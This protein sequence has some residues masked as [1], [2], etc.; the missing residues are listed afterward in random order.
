MPLMPKAHLPSGLAHALMAG[1]CLLMGGCTAA[2]DG[3]Q[4]RITQIAPT[5]VCSDQSATVGL[6]GQNFAP[7]QAGSGDGLRLPSVQ[8]QRIG[9]TDTVL[10]DGASSQALHWDNAQQMRLDL[11]AQSLRAGLWQVEITNPGGGRAVAPAP[12][13]LQGAPTID[14]IVGD[15]GCANT[16]HD[17]TYIL[18]G[19]NFVILG[20][21]PPTV[22]IDGQAL[23]PTW[24]ASACSAPAG[25][26]R[27]VVCNRLTVQVPAAFTAG[28]HTVTVQNPAPSTSCNNLV[29]SSNLDI[30]GVVPMVSH[31][32]APGSVS[33]CAGG[34]PLTIDGNFLSA[35]ASVRIGASAAP[36]VTGSGCVANLD[37]CSTVVANFGTITAASPAA[38][39][40][41]NPGAC[42]VQ[43][44]AV[45]NVIPGPQVYGVDPAVV[46]DGIPNKLTLYLHGVNSTVTSVIAS[47]AG[48]GTALTLCGGSAPACT[49]QALQSGAAGDQAL[50]L[51]LPAGSLA[52]LTGDA[53]QAAVTLEVRVADN[54][55]SALLPAGL[56]IANRQPDIALGV[57]PSTVQVG[58]HRT[59]TV[60]TSDPHIAPG[61]RLYYAG[62]NLQ[63]SFVQST[64]QDNRTFMAAAPS[65]SLSGN[66]ADVD[67]VLVNPDGTVYVQP[68]GL[69]LIAASMPTV[70]DMSG[71]IVSGQHGGTLTTQTTNLDSN[72][73]ASLVSC[74]APDGQAQPDVALGVTL[75]AN[76]LQLTTPQ[77]GLVPQRC[78]LQVTRLSD[79][80]QVLGG[81]VFLSD[82]ASSLPSTRDAQQPLRVA[83]RRHGIAATIS[84]AS[85][86]SLVIAGGDN[87]QSPLASVE[88]A[89]IGANGALG[90][91]V[92]SPYSLRTPRSSASLL[93]V[94]NST[95]YAIGGAD[96]AGNGITTVERAVV[97]NVNDAPTDLH[98][99]AFAYG[100]NGL[101]GLAA[102]DWA[103]TVSLLYTAN[104]ALY[105]CGESLPAAPITVGASSAP[106]GYIPTV[107]WSVPNTHRPLRGVR[108]YRGTVNGGSSSLRY[109]TDLVA[110]DGNFVFTDGS[111][112]GQSPA[113]LCAPASADQ[114]PLAAGAL[115]PWTQL[116]AQ[117]TRPRA[118]GSFAVATHASSRTSH[119][120]A[121][122]GLGN[123]APLQDYEVMNL[124]AV[125][126]TTPD[127]WEA[128]QTFTAAS[129]PNV[130]GTPCVGS[131]ARVQAGAVVLNSG[132]SSQDGVTFSI[133]DE[134]QYL[135]LGPGAGAAASIAAVDA[136][137]VA[138]NGQLQDVGVHT[139][140]SKAA[141]AQQS[142]GMA[143]RSQLVWLGGSVN[144]AGVRLTP[145]AVSSGTLSVT[146]PEMD[147][148][149]LLVAPR[150]QAAGVS[151]GGYLYL[152]GGLA[153]PGVQGSVEYG[154]W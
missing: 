11:P 75:N 144:T 126:G 76:T 119:I 87:G 135:A 94:G 37:S 97:L 98:L 67:V 89:A 107:A 54:T 129:L 109:L 143:L 18:R 61:A 77:V 31:P 106:L 71:A 142:V 52:A 154:M 26:L 92:M 125:D 49:T 151:H 110:S 17:R 3:P 118:G 149:T 88:I 102:G 84:D 25:D 101:M 133:T 122:G 68:K 93:R 148:G 69:R 141:A 36:V 9:T 111:A 134:T 13:W 91:W 136:W 5:S 112:Q 90:P 121:L 62:S 29:A 53:N 81:A 82:S 85:L 80:A 60:T 20:S 38:L 43:M 113:A 51:G 116:D 41:Q 55:C 128:S 59:L 108:I 153:T 2:P 99:Q 127:Q 57:S 131:T 96:A 139:C 147:N 132:N 150:V 65:I 74:N 95:L 100:A 27:V 44:D 8:F 6:A 39:T 83:R 78:Q 137:Q 45:V 145:W 152:T 138:T 16:P 56:L 7:A 73:K 15:D 72:S 79:G 64:V 103:Y 46:Y 34:G 24:D 21:T 63:G 115:S 33:L 47:V 105:P 40:V 140:L 50:A 14:S 1:V 114:A 146:T 58:S 86:H 19:S 124:T 4:P 123:G 48:G 117:L 66:F 42:A 23:V 120:L 28:S 104:D 30:E 32:T 35:Q 12:L 70:G 130:G 22:Q 10:F